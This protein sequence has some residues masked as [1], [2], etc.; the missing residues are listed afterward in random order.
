MRVPVPRHIEVRL[1][2]A[3]LAR[4]PG[5]CLCAE[6]GQART[7]RPYEPFAGLGII[8]GCGP[9]RMLLADVSLQERSYST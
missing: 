9:N 6:R 4:Q 8:E 5:L 1:G 3:S 7:P 2:R